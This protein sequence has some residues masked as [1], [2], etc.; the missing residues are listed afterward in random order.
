MV[1]KFGCLPGLNSF[2]K[3]SDFFCDTSPAKVFLRIHSKIIQALVE[4]IKLILFHS[5]SSWHTNHHQNEHDDEQI[6]GLPKRGFRSHH[7]E[8]S[9]PI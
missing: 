2:G 3:F 6:G 4:R 5:L 9:D 8:D 7:G 1:Y